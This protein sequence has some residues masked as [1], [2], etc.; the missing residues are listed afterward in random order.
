MG[1]GIA[2]LFERALPEGEASAENIAR[3]RACFTA[4]YKDH[5]TDATRPY[6]GVPELLS[7]L[8][9]KGLKLAVASNKYHAATEQLVAHY[10]PDLPF[11]AVIGHQKGK[12]TK[13]DPSIVQEILDKSGI[14]AENTV[15]VGDSGVDMQTAINSQTIAC[16]ISWGLRPRSELESY[17]PDF[18]VD[19]TAELRK[20]LLQTK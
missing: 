13:P 16:G 15:F 18:L 19:N 12:A 17:K 20:V 8:H 2:R 6:A 3:M 11:V 4:R 7:E 5:M 1:N 10:F 14:P 9:Q